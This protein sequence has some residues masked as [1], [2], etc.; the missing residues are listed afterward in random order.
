MR[1]IYLVRTKLERHYL[2][3][4][5]L[6]LILP[7]LIIGGALYYVIFYFMTEQLGI[8]E[9]II[10]QLT[11]VVNKVNLLLMILLP[12][13]F[14]AL[15]SVGLVLTRNL[16]GPVERLDKELEKI[17]SE[18]LFSERLKLREKDALKPFANHINILLDK[19]E[20]KNLE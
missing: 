8:P 12:P 10:S 7:A 3:L 4:L 17:I 20:K 14:L 15:L 13:I 2:R 1:K 5:E 18:N 19:V 11:P 9:V 6:S 16:A